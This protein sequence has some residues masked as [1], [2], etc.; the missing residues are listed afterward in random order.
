MKDLPETHK[1]TISELGANPNKVLSQAGDQP[2]VILSQNK[3][4]AYLVP[5]ETF[6]QMQEEIDDYRLLKEAQERTTDEA[7][8]VSVE[9]L[10][11]GTEEKRRS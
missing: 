5:I 4:W 11:S 1:A 8:S 2:V 3:A 9:Q 6:E 10:R 7:V